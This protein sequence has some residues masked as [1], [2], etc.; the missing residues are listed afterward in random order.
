MS[1]MTETIELTEVS[2]D[3]IIT[4]LNDELKQTERELREIRELAKTLGIEVKTQHTELKNVERNT[5]KTAD[6]TN[7][8]T[9]TLKETVVMV[10]DKKSGSGFLSTVAVALPAIIGGAVGGPAGMFI[11]GIGVA[12]VGTLGGA[13]VGAGVGYISSKF[14]L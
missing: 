6:N 12:I 2:D 14:I 10:R 3:K 9:V 7:A 8:G 5:I 1:T 11:G 4:Q 13:A